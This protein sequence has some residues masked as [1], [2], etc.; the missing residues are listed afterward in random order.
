[1]PHSIQVHPIPQNVTLFGNEGFADVITVRTEMRPYW[2]RR[3]PKSN[4]SILIGDR[5]GRTQVQRRQRED[6]VRDWNGAF[7]GQ[8]MLRTAGSHQ[9]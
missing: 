3:G 2:F 9:R 8:G 1:M 4:E 6:G 7:T 5:K